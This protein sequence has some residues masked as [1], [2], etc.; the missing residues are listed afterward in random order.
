MS[1]RRRIVEDEAIDPQRK[2]E[3]AIREALAA[4]VDVDQAWTNAAHRHFA[5]T[6]EQLRARLDYYRPKPPDL[7]KIVYDPII[8]GMF[9]VQGLPEGV[10]KISWRYRINV[11]ESCRKMGITLDELLQKKWTADSAQGRVKRGYVQQRALRL[12]RCEGKTLMQPWT[13]PQK[14]TDQGA[15]NGNQG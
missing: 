3:A 2:V 5:D 9:W 12:G 11:E 14:S 4:G 8:G 6:I 13:D 10:Q 7:S 1:R 15:T